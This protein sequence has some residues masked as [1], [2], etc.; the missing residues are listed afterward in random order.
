MVCATLAMVSTLPRSHGRRRAAIA[1]G[2]LTDEP[3]G[4][5]RDAH[6]HMAAEII[7]QPREGVGETGVEGHR[8]DDGRVCNAQAS[9]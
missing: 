7:G 3:Q 1:S 5:R 4:Q 9:R 8:G 2:R 6:Q